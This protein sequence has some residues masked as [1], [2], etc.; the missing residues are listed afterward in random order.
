MQNYMHSFAQH[1][2]IGL[3]PL[4]RVVNAFYFLKER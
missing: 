4:R 2:G 1:K 3:C